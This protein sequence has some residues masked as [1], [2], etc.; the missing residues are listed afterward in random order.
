MSIICTCGVPGALFCNGRNGCHFNA[1][2]G[3]QAK[4]T[5]EK[6]KT[7]NTQLPAEV[8][9][10]IQKEAEAFANKTFAGRT[11]STPHHIRYHNY[12]EI[13]TEY[14]TKLHQAHQEI[15]SLTNQLK[16]HAGVSNE[17]LK[18]LKLENVALK[19]KGQKLARYARSLRLSVTA[20]P[21]Y[22]GEPN[23]EWTDLVEGVDE[24][25]AEWKGEKEPAQEELTIS[26]YEEVLSDH[27]RLVHD[28]DVIINGEN[29]A[30]QAALGDMVSQIR[31]LWPK[32]TQ[33]A[34]WVKA[35]ERLPKHPDDPGNHFRL[36]GRKVNGNFYNDNDGMIFFEVRGSTHEPY[37]IGWKSFVYLEWLDESAMKDEWI[38]VHD[39]LPAES[40]RYW[41]YIKELTDL[42]FSYFQWNCYYNAKERRFSDSTLT[43]GENVTHWRPLPE[44]PKR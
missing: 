37:T 31:N 19:A 29:A 10:R 8:V 28:L 12:I 17:N 18:L 6:P 38:S 14:A 9:L 43:N 36:H 13:A 20:H 41:C 33:G 15:E 23:A 44:P 30:K 21:H 22:T 2:T 26:D 3:E 16:G 25:L 42:A 5:A 1:V 35:S 24:A 40:G 7:N 32:R 39:R 11:F 34:V 27:R 4:Q